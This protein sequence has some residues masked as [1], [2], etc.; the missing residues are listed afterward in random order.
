MRTA[1]RKL[2]TKGIRPR[3]DQIE[4][5][6]RLMEHDP[7]LTWSIAIRRGLDMFIT[8]RMG[9]LAQ[10]KSSSVSAHI[11]RSLWLSSGSDL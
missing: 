7:E 9:M 8:E 6:E 1:A 10:S 5:L 4:K 11:V 3:S 2:S